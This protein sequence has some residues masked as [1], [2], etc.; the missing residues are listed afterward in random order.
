MWFAFALFVDV[1]ENRG[2][3]EFPLAVEQ[4]PR[5]AGGPRL[6]QFPAERDL[7]VPPAGERQLLDGYGWVDKKAGTVRIPIAE[8]MR[9]TVERGLPSRADDG[10][11]GQSATRRRSMPADASAGRT[12][13]RR[14][15]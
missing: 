11:S 4:E 15:Q 5:A 7:R 10:T 3:S 6:Q 8:A 1:S 13:E 12:M 9:L 2:P 14:R